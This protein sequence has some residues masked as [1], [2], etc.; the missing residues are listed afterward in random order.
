MIEIE[1]M[2]SSAINELL[3]RVYYGHLGCAEHNQPYVVPIHF[4]YDGDFFYIFTT[5]GKKSEI[6]DVN[7]NVCIQLE[8]ILENDHWQSVLVTGEAT[9]VTDD[10]ERAKAMTL[11]RAVNPTLNPALSIRWMD[12]WVQEIRDIEKVYRIK[13]TS[14]TGRSTV[15]TKSAE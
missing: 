2:L 10:A 6:I 9:A 15:V 13:P 7:P 11:I 3:K 5:P 4:V 1:S 14:I 8:E 12:S